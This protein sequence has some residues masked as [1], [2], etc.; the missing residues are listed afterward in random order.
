MA[1]IP[2]VSLSPE[3]WALLYL[4]KELGNEVSTN[5][6]GY[7]SVKGKTYTTSSVKFSIYDCSQ[8]PVDTL[9]LQYHSIT[10]YTQMSRWLKL[11]KIKVYFPYMA[12]II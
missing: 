3:D 5:V 12:M 1:A 11:N 4:A 6:G 9:I 8:Q 2:T 7:T 10:A